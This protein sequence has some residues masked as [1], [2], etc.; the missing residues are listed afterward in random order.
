MIIRRLPILL[1]VTLASFGLVS[2]VLAAAGQAYETADHI[3]ANP[4]HSPTNRTI[5]TVQSPRNHTAA[6][7]LS[8]LQLQVNYG[9]DWV[10]GETDPNATVT[11]T[12]TDNVRAVKAEALLQADEIGHFLTTCESWS[13]GGCPDIQPGDHVHVESTGVTGSISPIGSLL[14]EVD[15]ASDLV[16]VTLNANWLSDNTDVQC[17]ILGELTPN[18]INTTSNPDGGQFACDFGEVGWDLQVSD[19]VAISYF[20]DDGDQVINTIEWPFLAANIGPWSDGNRHIWGSSPSPNASVILTVTTDLG[21]FIAG[22]T[23]FPDMNGYFNTGNDFPE[24]TL[25]PWNILYADFGGIITDSLSMYPMSGSANPETNIITVTAAGPPTYTIDL[26]ICAP[27]ETCDWVDLG[28]IGYSGVITSDIMNDYSIDVVHGTRLNAHMNV[29]NGHNIVYSWGLPAPELG[30]WK[31]HVGEYARPGGIIIYG[32]HYRND[33]NGPAENVVIKDTVPPYTSYAAD[34]NGFPVTVGPLNEISWEL[35]T[36]EPGE[37]AIYYVTLNVDPNTLL[38]TGTIDQNCAVIMSS[39]PGD[40]EPENDLSCSQVV[41]VWEDEVDLS[42]RKWAEPSDPHPGQEFDYR[43][44]W[45]NLRGAS[46]GPVVMTDTLPVGVSLIEWQ[47]SEPGMHFWYQ[48]TADEQQVV[49][50]APGLPGNRCETIKIRASLDAEVVI[51]T[52]LINLINLYIHG[53]VNPEN[54][55]WVDE[56]TFASPTRYDLAI[57]KE[58]GGAVLVPG[59]YVDFWLGYHNHG[60][61]ESTVRITDTLPPG[62]VYVS[63]TWGEETPWAGEAIPEPITFGNQLVW[64]MPAVRV[65]EQRGVNIRLAIVET[66]SP[67]TGMENCAKIEGEELDENSADNIA[68]SSFTVQPLGP[69][70]QVEKWSE[71]RGEEQ[72]GY[73]IRFANIGNQAVT[74][75]WITDTLPVGVIPSSWPE[76]HFGEQRTGET[77]DDIENGLWLFKFAEIYPGEVGTI[78]FNVD[79]LEPSAPL[80][81]YT[82]TV[83]IS[84]PMGEV[85]PADNF[86]QDIV[87]KQLP[88]IF[89]PITLINKQ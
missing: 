14:G 45:C 89:L 35:G 60:N 64:E 8:F 59:G 47:E 34:T 77:I 25:A 39:T 78:N 37:S 85:T 70:L 56:S 73:T 36:I 63:G 18:P 67:G 7:T 49:F 65:N 24:G 62:L 87:I 53:D 50:W 3:L 6:V 26:E 75:V 20:E 41:D 57:E 54:N 32:I 1:L 76:I 86:F 21:D 52:K 42:V 82:N 83:D 84:L 15:Y 16:T 51:H 66:V 33:G 38:G 11:I 12:I 29:R 61:V 43:I 55:W 69:N 88:K 2:V 9:H 4:L 79:L 81:W 13:P 19:I 22:T 30:L 74:G 72:L 27:D 17:E 5:K 28:E 40:W 71:W 80:R 44:E 31:W 10:A 68:C 23:T 48:I 58:Q 46:A